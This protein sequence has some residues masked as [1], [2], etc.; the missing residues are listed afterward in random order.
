MDDTS[1]DKV[2]PVNAYV[3]ATIALHAAT[4]SKALADVAAALEGATVVSSRAKE[5]RARRSRLM[6]ETDAWNL[7]H[8]YAKGIRP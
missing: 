1:P 6:A 4:A 8:D 5:L 2:R 7:V 3:L